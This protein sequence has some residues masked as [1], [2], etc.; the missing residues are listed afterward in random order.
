MG[1][2]SHSYSEILPPIC[3]TNQC[4]DDDLVRKK[5]FKDKMEMSTKLSLLTVGQSFEFRTK[6]LVRE[7]YILSCVDKRCS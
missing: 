6:Y 1:E 4:D 3:F 7:H 2:N 5:F